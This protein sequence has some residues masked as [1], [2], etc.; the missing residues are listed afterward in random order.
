MIY[1]AEEQGK[2]DPRPP[3]YVNSR[4]DRR[5]QKAQAQDQA[6]NVVDGVTVP[7]LQAG[8]NTV[9]AGDAGVE[10]M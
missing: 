8:S 5:A 7:T 9:G 10:K 1:S 4:S 6:V 2:L 3:T